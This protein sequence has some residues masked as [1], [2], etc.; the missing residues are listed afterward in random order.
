MDLVEQARRLSRQV[1]Q[2]RGGHY[3]PVVADEVLQHFQA[4]QARGGSVAVVEGE[5]G[6]G[7][8]TLYR[9][10][11]AVRAPVRLRHVEET[12]LDGPGHLLGEFVQLI[13][14][15]GARVSH[16]VELN[17]KGSHVIEASAELAELLLVVEAGLIAAVIASIV[18]VSALVHSVC[19]AAAVDREPST[20]ASALRK[21]DRASRKV[22]RAPRRVL[23]SVAKPREQMVSD[24]YHRVSDA[25]ARSK[26]RAERVSDDATRA[27]DAR[28]GARDAEREA[29]EDDDLA[30]EPREVAGDDFVVANDARDRASEVGAVA[31]DAMRPVR[32]ATLRVSDGNG[33]ASLPS[34][35][36]NEPS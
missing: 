13:A 24:A 21:V 12:D 7:L 6:F 11:R 8:D 15:L 22:Q 19:G 35:C 29:S 27:S 26:L 18:S 34:C 9:W 17:R 28:R 14:E 32:H 25:A 16:V 1:A 36:V 5:L 33:G 20:W 3:S 31:S 23:S 30:G 10:R 4:R 2:H